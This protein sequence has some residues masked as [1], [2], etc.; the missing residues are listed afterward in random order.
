[1]LEIRNKRIAGIYLAEFLRLYEH[2]RARAIAIAEKQRG[3]T[4]R[5]VLQPNGGWAKKYFVKGSPEEKSRL[6][7]A[8]GADWNVTWPGRGNIGPASRSRAATRSPSC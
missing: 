4:E 7:L 8:H 6:R 1:V 3:K 5:P 2:Y